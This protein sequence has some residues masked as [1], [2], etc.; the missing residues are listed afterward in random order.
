MKKPFSFDQRSGTVVCS[1]PKCAQVRGAE[2]VARMPIKEN[3]VARQ[4]T[5]KPLMCY[6][7][8]AFFKTGRNRHQRKAEDAKRR[9]V[10]QAKVLETMT[11]MA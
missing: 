2:G 4:T 9:A 6:D 5:I 3:V 7:C 8:N 11:A 10:I 1:N